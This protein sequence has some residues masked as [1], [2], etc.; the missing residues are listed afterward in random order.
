M[1]R[2]AIPIAIAIGFVTS[3]QAEP[4][5]TDEERRKTSEIASTYK[6]CLSERNNDEWKKTYT[7]DETENF[8]GCFSVLI[9]DRVTV[10]EWKADVAAGIWQKNP[11]LIETSTYCKS[12]YMNLPD[13]TAIRKKKW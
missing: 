11:K 13:V 4:P 5:T 10:E 2:V 8:C 9:N 6:R 12:K 3:A 1:K 7:S